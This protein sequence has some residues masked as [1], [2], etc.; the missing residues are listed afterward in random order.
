MLTK[1]E[2]LTQ[3]KNE[4]EKKKCK[5]CGNNLAFRGVRNTGIIEGREE[6]GQIDSYCQVCGKVAII[7]IHIGN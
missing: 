4:V 2:F 1:I 7:K 6:V 3:L 5:D